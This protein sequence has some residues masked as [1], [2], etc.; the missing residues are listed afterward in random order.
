MVLQCYLH[1]A[2]HHW[3]CCYKGVNMKGLQT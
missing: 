2:P 3:T 1:W